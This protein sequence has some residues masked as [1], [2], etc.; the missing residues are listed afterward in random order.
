MLDRSTPSYDLSIKTILGG[1][2]ANFNFG[3]IQSKDSL[4]CSEKLCLEVTKSCQI[5]A[6]VSIYSDDLEGPE[7][8]HLVV[9]VTAR[10]RSYSVSEVIRLSN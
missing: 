6:N 3:K 8:S 4:I 5:S 9:K 1:F 2:R 7:K 10:E